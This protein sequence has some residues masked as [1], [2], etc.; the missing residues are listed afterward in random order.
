MGKASVKL[1]GISLCF[2]L[3]ASLAPRIASA[4][5]VTFEKQDAGFRAGVDYSE[6]GMGYAF[7]WNFILS[8]D[9]GNPPS[10]LVGFPAAIG[11]FPDAPDGPAIF[12]TDTTSGRRFTFDG[13]DIAALDPNQQS[14]TWLFRG[15]LR[16]VE[17]FSFLDSTMGGFATRVTK[18][19]AYIDRLEL[20]VTPESTTAVVVDNLRFTFDPGS[21]EIPEPGSVAAFSIGLG[22]LAAMRLRR[23]GASA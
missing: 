6:S 15:L 2:A 3:A 5:V 17:Q 12:S 9:V 20:R 13:Y 11:P 4:E 8:P 23:P 14:G 10:A 16:D 7:F 18:Q 1:I 19:N 21:V 22:L